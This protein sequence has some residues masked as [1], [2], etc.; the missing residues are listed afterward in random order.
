MP[1]RG[2][3]YTD[4]EH[5]AHH[6]LLADDSVTIQR[7]VALAL[8]DEEVR[9]SAVGS[10]RQA[11][12]LIATDPPDL[13]LADVGMPDGDGY[14]VLEHIR[15]TPPLS[16]I[17]VLLLTSAFEPV[18]EARARTAGCT[19]TLTKPF[20]PQ[21]LIGRVRELLGA[22]VAGEG[23]GEPSP[24][25]APAPVRSAPIA[26]PDGRAET[27]KVAVGIKRGPAPPIVRASDEGGAV[28]PPARVAPEDE[29][30]TL[31][32]VPANPVL[33]PQAPAESEDFAS[34]QEFLQ[35]PVSN[36]DAV[37]AAPTPAA[38]AAPHE[39]GPGPESLSLP[40]AS[41]PAPET[42]A[43]PSDAVRATA[44]ESASASDLQLNAEPPV[45]DFTYQPSSESRPVWFRAAL[46]L[47]M[48][49]LVAL[50]VYWLKRPATQPVVPVTEQAVSTAPDSRGTLGPLV[51]PLDL[52]PLDLT[53]TLV[54]ELLGRLSSRPELVRWLATSGLIRNAV[55][56]IDNV[57]EGRSPAQHLQAL[58][59]KGPFRV[60]GEGAVLRTDP[61]S[62]QRYDSLADTVAAL[63]VNALARVY[64]ALKPRLAEAYR[65]L[66]HPEG[67]ID[68]AVERALVHV[69]QTPAVPTD[70][71][72]N[73]VIVSYEY[74][75]AR[76]EGLSAAQ[77]QLARMGPRNQRLV[78]SRL[79]DLGLAL[80]I[81]EARLP[82]PPGSGR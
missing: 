48:L 41:A 37:S 24:E 14:E 18:D 27:V 82:V 36:R 16:H 32:L 64:A 56:V 7:V 29:R 54:R 79:R 65:D 6:L 30:P 49:A 51:D 81:S 75:D 5:M 60:A 70:A 72:L 13:V 20:D 12:A 25:I 34:T 66:G 15:A 17:P 10:G 1:R 2:T 9:V 67:D 78:Q 43:A 57:A 58:A 11:I 45:P 55:V 63:D 71:G 33:S 8:A 46:V 69:L 23:A 40:V 21:R 4:P 80:G 77:K 73:D 42:A 76:F 68:A 74:A 38:F 47:V 53:D 39:P 26:A 61:Q 28:P 62:F 52:P 44:E 35:P 19:G 3:G 50:G 59:P 22:G 31:P